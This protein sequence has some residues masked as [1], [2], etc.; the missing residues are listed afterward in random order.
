MVLGLDQNDDTGEC[1]TDNTRSDGEGPALQ[2]G[3]QDCRKIFAAKTNLTRQDSQ[4]HPGEKRNRSAIPSR[5]LFLTAMT[6]VRQEV[7]APR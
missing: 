4:D 3:A 2:F 5:R 7:M 1:S 6:G